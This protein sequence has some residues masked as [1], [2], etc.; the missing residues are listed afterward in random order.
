MGNNRFVKNTSWLMAGQVLRLILSFF[1]GIITAR[2]L[3]KTNLGTIEYVASYI[4]FFTALIGFGLNGIVVHEFVNHS[5]SEGKI[6]GTAIF[7]R[8]AVGLISIPAFLALVFAIDG[9]DKTIMA[10]ALMQSLQLPFLCF[11]TINYWYQYKSKSKYV[12]I[13]QTI[14]YIASALYKIVLLITEKSV[15]WFAVAVSIDY[16]VLGMLYMFIYN[17][18]KEQ[19]LGLSMDVAKRILKN[20]IPFVL[21]ELMVVICSQSDR[22]MIKHLMDNTTDNVGLYSSAMTICTMVSFIPLAILDSARPFIARAKAENEQL[23]RVRFSQLLCA[24]MWLLFAYSAFVS[25]F[26]KLI[27]YIMYG[28]EFMGAVNCLRIAVW[29]GAF[30]Y[31]GGAL[32]FW[33]I[34]ENKKKYVF[35]FSVLGAVF[36]IALNFIFI[37]LWGINGAAFTMVM[38]QIFKNAVLPML[39]KETRGFTKCTLDG[40]L[41]RHVTVKDILSLVPK[42]SKDDNKE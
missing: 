12:V 5:D 19:K 38:T 6:L 13:I 36:S 4:A 28:A 1:V 42:K 24:L 16:I 15:G 8:F 37:P 3:G 7:M 20:C 25:I 21:S 14:A 27:V 31:L 35:L 34:C 17:K 32:S 41:F 39:F 33:F 22:I 23:Y 11:D 29:Y 30:S 26:A 40:L 9:Y 10:V 2:Y 18:H